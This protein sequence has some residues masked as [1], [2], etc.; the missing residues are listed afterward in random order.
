MGT[1]IGHQF[2]AGSPAFKELTALGALSGRKPGGFAL[3]SEATLRDLRSTVFA[4]LIGKHIAASSANASSSSA[5]RRSM[6]PM[7]DC[8]LVIETKHVSA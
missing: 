7:T 4:A 5:L 3:T 8:K 1:R 2:V 6:L